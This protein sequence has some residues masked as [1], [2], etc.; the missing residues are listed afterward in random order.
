MSRRAIAT[1]I[2]ATGEGGGVFISVSVVKSLELKLR[3]AVLSRYN[4][5][6]SD[7]QRIKLSTKSGFLILQERAKL[8]ASLRTRSPYVLMVVWAAFLLVAFYI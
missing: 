4:P 6:S 5:F 2:T 8:S 7:L 3:A 1:T